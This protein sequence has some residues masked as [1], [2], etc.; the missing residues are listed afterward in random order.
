MT[1]AAMQAMVDGIGR[2][3][4]L[5]RDFPLFLVEP[6]LLRRR[7][8]LQIDA[9]VVIGEQAGADWGERIRPNSGL[10]GIGQRAS[11]HGATGNLHPLYSLV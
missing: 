9:A 2:P 4:L 8:S 5:G 1:V 3:V 6:T 10:N 7:E 11:S